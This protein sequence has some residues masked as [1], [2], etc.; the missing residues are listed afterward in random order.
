MARSDSK[1]AGDRVPFPSNPWAR[2]VSMRRTALGAIPI[3]FL[4][5]FSVVPAH[6]QPSRVF[7]AAQ[8]NDANSCSFASPCRTFQHAHDVVAAGGEIDV[9]DPAGYGTVTITK[10]ISIQGHDFSGMT[11]PN[12]G[13]GITINAGAAD[14]VSLRG[15]IVDGA[16]V[17]LTGIAFLSG[18]SLTIEN[19]IVRNF[20]NSG[21]GLAPNASSILAVSNTLVADNSVNGI[22]LQPS[23]SGS[24]NA[25]FNRVEA[26]NNGQIGIGVF[27]NFTT[28]Y[29]SVLAIAAD[30][31]VAKTVGSD[32]SIASIGYYA[33]GPNEFTR[34]TVFRSV[35]SGY[36]KGVGAVDGA[37]AYVSQSNLENTV[38]PFAETTFGKVFSYG[39]N[40]SLGAPADHT[41]SKN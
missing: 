9:L 18:L 29:V 20:T 34:F 4:F 7:V 19:S 33:F 6:A 41:V 24:V 1:P 16:G 13:T 36:E 26:Y 32:G 31:V 30:C 35:A 28:P 37:V 5:T 12:G 40:Y 23:G 27:G 21:I 2:E 39:D 22:Y 11:V 14:K 10:S 3:V 8:G 15:L 25:V 38:Y 17:G